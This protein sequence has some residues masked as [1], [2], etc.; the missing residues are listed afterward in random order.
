MYL[1][2]L[3]HSADELN[4]AANPCVIGVLLEQ[5]S[6]PCEKYK[7]NNFLKPSF[8]NVFTP[9]NKHI[10]ETVLQF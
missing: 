2:I 7:T 4:S 9:E 5:Y 6:N 8:K 1:R 10:E 3:F